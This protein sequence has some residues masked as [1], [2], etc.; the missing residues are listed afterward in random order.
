MTIQQ[1]VEALQAEL[2][3]FPWLISV[4][5]GEPEPKQSIHVYA[6]TLKNTRLTELRHDGYAGF[7]VKVEKSSDSRPG[8]R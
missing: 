6:T 7:P 8:N 4:G 5:T 1:A 3:H 2:S